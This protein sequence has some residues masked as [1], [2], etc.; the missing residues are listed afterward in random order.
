MNQA[1]LEEIVK[2]QAHTFYKNNDGL[3][4]EIDYNRTIES[5]QNIKFI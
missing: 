2:E 1:K 4:R 5:K 3:V